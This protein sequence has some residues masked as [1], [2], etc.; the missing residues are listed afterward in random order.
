MHRKGETGW[1]VNR[2]VHLPAIACT[3]SIPKEGRMAQ[4]EDNYF[5]RHGDDVV[6]ENVQPARRFEVFQHTLF[7]WERRATL[8][9]AIREA[10]CF[11]RGNRSR[12]SLLIGLY[13]M[14]EVIPSTAGKPSIAVQIMV[15]HGIAE[16][17]RKNR[18]QPRLLEHGM[19]GQHDGANTGNASQQDVTNIQRQR[20]AAATFYASPIRSIVALSSE[21]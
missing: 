14:L 4:E 6:M 16:R 15:V 12:P 19:L 7:A 13:I 11:D 3:V 1:D 8:R 2:P 20:N 21:A 9:Q 18:N 17:Y 5:N 10:N